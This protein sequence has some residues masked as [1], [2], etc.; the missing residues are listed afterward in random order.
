[1]KI[2]IEKYYFDISNEREA[3]EYNKL[4]KKLKARGLVKFKVIGGDTVSSGEYTIEEEFLF[5]DQSNTDKLRVH[6]WY[7]QHMAVGMNK[8]VRRGYYILSGFKALQEA[9]RNR[10]KCGYCGAQYDKASAPAFCEACLD[11]PYLDKEHLPLLILRPVLRDKSQD[12]EPSEAIKAA[13]YNAFLTAQTARQEEDNEKAR[14]KII[15]KAARKIQETELERDGFLWALDHGINT[16]N[17]IYYSHSNTF[18]FG[19]KS[20]L[21]RD[22]VARLKKRLKGFPGKLEFKEA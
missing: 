12:K 20:P 5:D 14:G 21:D 7:E 16:G 8:N 15:K 19:W 13:L 1:M 9:R 22:V 11:S 4:E 10:Y 17:L 18:C 2:T 6:D 3:A